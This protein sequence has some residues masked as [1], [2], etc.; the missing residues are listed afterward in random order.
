M[1]DIQA[2]IA[3]RLTADPFT[4]LIVAS[5]DSISVF[6][7]DNAGNLNVVQSFDALSPGGFVSPLAVANTLSVDFVDPGPLADLVAIAP[8]DDAVLIYPGNVGGTFDAPTVYS[9]GV[10]TPTTAV[11]ADVLGDRL[12]D[13]IVGHADGSIVFFEGSASG[14]GSTLVRRDDLTLNED[15]SIVDLVPGDFDSDENSDIVVATTTSAFVLFSSDDPQAVSPIT[16]GDFSAGLTGWTTEVIGHDFSQTP[17]RIGGLGGMAQFTENES[18]L[19]SLK[20]SIVIPPGTTELSFD[21]V[22]LGLDPIAGGV[23]D[24]FEVSLLDDNEQ[25]IVPSHDPDSTAFVNFSSGNSASLASGVSVSGR[26][27]TLDVSSLASGTNATLVFDLIGNPPGHSSVAAIDNVRLNPNAVFSD[28][29]TRTDLVGNYGGL[30]DVEVGD[31]DGDGNDDIV[32]SSP[33]TDSIVVFNGDGAGGFSEDSLSLASYSSNPGDIQLAPLTAGDEVDDIVVVM[34]DENLLLTP[35]GADVTAPA[36]TLLAPDNTSSLETFDGNVTLEFSEALRVS[37]VGSANNLSAY[38]LIGEGPDGVFGTSDDVR[39]AF[40]SANYDAVAMTVLLAVDASALPLADDNYRITV[41]GSDPALA[42]RDRVGNAVGGGNDIEFDF[43]IDTP[44]TAQSIAAIRATEGVATTVSTPFTDAGRV[45]NYTATIDW[46]D[47]VVEPLT[48]SLDA[49][50]FA[51]DVLGGHIYADNGRYDIVL[52]ITDHDDGTAIVHSSVIVA[53]SDPVLSGFNDISASE[54]TT[55]EFTLAAVTDSGFATGST[56]E[57]FSA[58]I[59][60]GDGSTPTTIADVIETTTGPAGPTT[61]DV[62]A[63]HAYAGEG[64]YTVTVTVADDDGGSATGTLQ[65]FVS[66]TAPVLAAI[67]PV[68]GNE[69]AT[70]SIAGTYRDDD[71][72]P[73]VDPA[74]THTLSIDWGDGTTELLTPVADANSQ[75]S[76]LADHVYADD[77]NYDIRVKVIDGDNGMDLQIAPATVGG[78]VPTTVAAANVQATAGTPMSFTLASFSD[79]GFTSS[80]AG[81]A[82]TFSVSVDWGDGSQITVDPSVVVTNGRPGINTTGLVSA[83][84]V[85]AAAGNYTATITVTDD[86]GLSSSDSLT[87]TVNGDDPTGACLPTLNFDQ[88]LSGVDLDAGT[89]IAEQWALWG[90]HISTDDPANHPAMIFDAENPTGGDTDLVSPAGTMLGNIL[91]ISEDNDSSDPD[92]NASGGTLIFDFDNPV[93]LDEVALLDID[94]NE[95]SAITLLDTSGNVIRA[96]TTIGSGD[97]TLQTVMLD[98]DN[99][100]RM[101]I[102]IDGSGAVTEVVFC[103]DLPTV[104]IVGNASAT[105]GTSYNVLTLSPD[106]AVTSWQLNFGDGT[107]QTLAGDAPTTIETFADGPGETTISG[108]AT[109][110]MNVYPASSLSVSI[111]NVIPTLS[112]SGGATVHAMTDYMIDLS[113]TDPGTD[114]IAGWVVDWGDGTLQQIAGNPNS[115]THTYEVEGEY[116]VVAHAFDEDYDGPSVGVTTPIEINAR[117]QEGVETFDLLIDDAVV[118]GF[119]TTTDLQTFAYDAA[120]AIAPNQIKIQFTNDL[121]DP[122]NGIDNNLIVDSITIAGQEYQTEADDVW[123]TGTWKSEDGI[124]DGYRGSEWLHSGGYFHFDH[125]ADDGSTIEITARGSEGFETLDLLIGGVIVASYSASTADQIFTYNAANVISADDV[126]IE[127]TNDFWDPANGIDAN[128]I[129][130]SINIDGRNYETEDSSVYSTGTWKPEDGI[131]PGY[132]ASEWMHAG[133]YFQYAGGFAGEVTANGIFNTGWVSNE[134]TLNVMPSNSLWL[135]DVNFDVDPAGVPLAAGTRITDQFASLGFTV[136]TNNANKPAMIFDS[137]QPTGGDQDLGTPNSHYG[138]PGRGNSGG[139]NDMALRNVL[140]ISE[141]NDAGDPDDNGNGGTLIFDFDNPVMIDEVGIM[142]IDSA[143][144]RIDLFDAVGALILSAPIESVG[145]NGVGRV[146]LDATGVSK[147][148][149]VLTG[150]GAVT[151]IEFCR[152]GAPIATAQTRFFVVD[153]KDDDIYRYATGGTSLGDFDASAAYNPRGITTTGEGNPVWVISEEGSPERVYVYD[154]DG[155][156]LLGDWTAKNLSNP[157]GIATDGTDIWVVDRSSDKVK[158]YAGGATRRAGHQYPADEFRLAYGNQDPRGITTDGQT[159]WVVDTGSDRVF[160]YDIAGNPI[161]WWDLDDKNTSPRGITINPNGGDGVWVVDSGDDAVYHYANAT[162]PHLGNRQSAVNVF[163]LAPGNNHPEGIA[164][165]VTMI[166]LGDSVSDNVSVAGEVDEWIFD[167]TVADTDIFVDFTTLAGGALTVSIT[168]PDGSSLFNRTSSFTGSLDSKRLTLPQVGTHTI[169]VTSTATATYD[170]TLNE[171][172]DD[173]IEPIVFGQVV[174]G[175]QDPIG[176]VDRYSFNADAGTKIFLDRLN[177]SGNS[178]LIQI[179]SPSGQKLLGSLAFLTDFNRSL[180][181]P[182]TGTYLFSVAYLSANPL[183]YSFRFADVTNVPTGSIQLN[184]LIEGTVD[185]PGRQLDYTF[186]ITAPIDVVLDAVQTASGQTWK[187]FDPNGIQVYSSLTMSD[188]LKFSLTDVGQYTLS[189]LPTNG[190]TG[191]ISFI[192]WDSTNP[193]P[194]RISPN[195]A[196]SQVVAPQ[197]DFVY[198]IDL[199]AGQDFLFDVQVNQSDRPSIAS[200]STFTLTAPDGSDL[201]VS[202]TLDQ[203]YTTAPLSG[204]YTLSTASFNPGFRDLDGNYTFRIQQRVVAGDPGTADSAGTEYYL[205]AN[206]GLFAIIEPKLVL[207]ST[208]TD[209]V[210]AVIDL[211]GLGW[212]HAT[213]VPPGEAVLVPLPRDILLPRGDRE[214]TELLGIYVLADAEIRAYVLLDAINSGDATTG[215]PT[216]ALGTEYLVETYGTTCPLG[217]SSSKLSVVATQDDTIVTITPT[218][219]AGQSPDR[220]EAGVPYDVFLDAGQTYQLQ[221]GGLVGNAELSGTEILSN[222]PVAVYGGNPETYVTTEGQADILAQQMPPVAAWGTRYV[223]VPLAGR[224]GGDTFRVMASVD[225]TDVTINGGIVATL[226]RGETYQSIIDGPAEFT[227]DAPVMVTRFGHGG[228]FDNPNAG[229]D[230][231]ETTGD[232]L[233]ITLVPTEQFEDGFVVLSDGEGINDHYLSIVTFTDGIDSVAVDPADFVAIGDGTFSGASLLVAAGT[234]SITSDTPTSVEVYGFGN[235]DSYGYYGG[236]RISPVGR[237]STLSLDP[238]TASLLPGN[239]HTVT[240]SVVDSVGQPLADVRVDFSVTGTTAETF[241]AYSGIDGLVSFTYTSDDIGT[242]TVTAAVG[243]ITATAD[244]NWL[245]APPTVFVTSPDQGATVVANTPLVIGGRALPGPSGGRIVAVSINGRRVDSIDP[246]GNYFASVTPAEG[247]QSYEIVAIDQYGQSATTSLTLDGQ[248][249]EVPFALS[250][251]VD[252]T[253][254]GELTFARTTFN[255]STNVLHTDAVLTATSDDGL[256]MATSVI[257]HPIDPSRVTLNAPDFTLPLAGGSDAVADGEGISFEGQI[258]DSGLA[259]GQSSAA[260]DIDF[261]N[262]DR[263]RFSFDYVILSSDNRA[264]VISSSPLINAAIGQPYEYSIIASDPDGDSLTYRMTSGPATANLDV[265]G[266]LSFAPVQADRGTH[267]IAIAVD[268]SRG[269]ITTESFTLVVGD[270]VP[271]R[272]PI[273]D[274]APLAGIASGDDYRFTTSAT[275]PDGDAVTYSLDQGP[276]GLNVDGTSG[277]LSWTGPGDGNYPITLRASDPGGAYS[278]QNFNLA[279]GDSGVVNAA[280]RLFGDFATTATVDSLYVEFPTAVDADGDTLTFDLLVAPVG[281]TITTVSAD[282]NDAR[283]R[284]DYTPTAADVGPQPVLLVVSDGNGGSSSRSFNVNVEA[285]ATP[286]PPVFDSTPGVFATVGQ[287]YDY[288]AIA[289]DPDGDDS[290]LTYS[291]LDGPANFQ[292]DPATGVVTFTP[293]TPGEVTVSIQATDA[294]GLTSG[295]T[296]TFDVRPVNVAPQFVSDPPPTVSAGAR[297]RYDALATDADDFVTYELISGPAGMKVSRNSGLTFWRPQPADIGNVGVTI[298]ATDDRGLSTEQTFTIGVTADVTPPLATVFIS[299]SPINIGE[300]SRISVDTGDDVAVASRTLTIDGVEVPIDSQDGYT[301]TAATAGIPHVVLTAVDT[302]GNTTTATLDPILRVLDP[303]DTTS[304]EIEITSPAPGDVVTYLTDIVGSVTDENLEYYEIQVALADTDDYSTISRVTFQPGAGG[305]GVVDDT[306][307]VFDPTMLA[308]DFYDVRVVAADT[309]GNVATLAAPLSVEGGAKLGNFR[310]ELT[311]LAI[312]LAGIPIQINRV[313]DTLDAPYNGD[314]GYGWKLDVASPRIRESVRISPA[315]AAGGGMFGANPFRLGTRVYINAPDGERVGFTFDPVPQPTL[316]G[317]RWT[318]RFTPDPGVYHQLEVDDVGLSQNPDGTFGLYLFGFNYNPDTYTL[319]TQD[320]MQYTYNQFDDIQL[321]SIKDR[322]NVTLTFDNTGIHS[323]VGPSITWTR[324]DQGRITEIL[325]TAGNPLAYTYTTSG[326]LESFTD[327]VGNVTTMTYLDDPKHHL[328]SITDPRD[329][330]VLSLAYDENGRLTGQ[331]DALGNSTAQSY[332]LE[333]NTEIIADRLG[334]ETTLVFDDRGNI[335]QEIDPLGFSTIYQYDGDDN[336]IAI[337]NRRGFTTNYEY[338]DRGNVTKITDALGGEMTMTFNAT[339]DLTSMTDQLGRLTQYG[340]DA[341]GNQ[342]EMIDA[343][344]N[345]MLQTFDDEGRVLTRTDMRGN[346]TNYRYDIGCGCPSLPGEVTYA[347]GTTVRIETE[348]RGI[349]TRITDQRGFS[350]NFDIDPAGRIASITDANGDTTT[351][352]YV[353]NLVTASTDALG[354]VTTYGHDERGNVTTITDPL[355]GVYRYEYDNAGDVIAEI[356]ELDRRTETVFDQRRD[357]IEV[358][359]AFGDSVRYRY[360]GNGNLSEF[361]DENEHRTTYT[362]DE[363]DRW[364]GTTDARGFNTS[365]NYDAVDNLIAFV[366]EIGEPTTYAYDVLD[367][368]T[369]MTAADGGVMTYAYDASGNR[370]RSTDPI[371][372]AT[373]RD[374]DNLDRLQSETDPDGFVT[375]YRY[376]AA[377]NLASLTDARGGVMRFEYDPLGRTTADIDQL[378]V[379]RAYNYDAVGNLVERIDRNGR[380]KTFVMDDLDRVITE[381]WT[382]PNDN[383]ANVITSTYDAVGNR[384]TLADQF[385]SHTF[386]YDVLHR[387]TF[388]SDSDALIG[389]THSL[390]YTYDPAG[391]RLSTTDADSVAVAYDYDDVD[392]LIGLTW[393]GSLIGSGAA[394]RY[395]RDGRGD[396]QQIDRFASAGATTPVGRTILTRDQIGRPT[397]MTHIDAADALLSDYDFTFDLAGQMLFETLDGITRTYDH[398]D[399]GQ[400]TGVTAADAALTQSFAYDGTGNRTVGGVTVDAANQILSD[401]AYEY[402]YDGEGN[403]TG[404]TRRDTGMAESYQYDHDNRLVGYTR[405]LATG[406]A[407]LIAEYRYDAAGRRISKTVTRPLDGTS[408]TI[409]YRYDGVEAWKDVDATGSTTARYL[410]GDRIDELTARHRVDA[411]LALYLRAHDGSVEAITDASGVVI[412]RTTYAAFG[413]IIAHTNP[414]VADRFGFTGREHDAETGLMHYRAR[415]Y[416]AAAGKFI[417]RD[418]LGLTAG[419]VN[420]TRY[421]G[422]APTEYVD[423][424]GKAAVGYGNKLRISAPLLGLRWQVQLGLGIPAGIAVGA[425]IGQNVNFGELL[426]IVFI[427]VADILDEFDDDDDGFNDPSGDGQGRPKTKGANRRDSQEID[428]VAKEKNVDRRELGDAVEKAKRG[429]GRGGSDNLTLDQIR[430]IADEII[431]FGNKVGD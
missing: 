35:L 406:E 3:Q 429:V 330:E 194:I 383:V 336:E 8:G 46:G 265:G 56:V 227:A 291:R 32:L 388:Q 17:G 277:G 319:V 54:N 268:D 359:N 211:P 390:T 164:D 29:L 425:Y 304:P 401:E 256:P 354:R 252:T 413:Q 70:V 416:D 254:S 208:S 371:G 47:G 239:P 165:P 95:S 44:I 192:I 428:R 410:P 393:S 386:A 154:T 40:D 395:Q 41:A 104:N 310:I 301:F 408:Q 195:T 245:G 100:A 160:A 140:I 293:T 120:G 112:I 231:S 64:N 345:S 271:N 93:Q 200:V 285:A 176:Q 103:R 326:D 37:G 403:R 219:L 235:F 243:N 364:A 53:N 155:E 15:S 338:D 109:D 272:G 409:G 21:L 322:N 137:S 384:L 361:V 217:C 287:S 159:I 358:I 309:N 87:I 18:F 423:P 188:S 156:T 392:D 105:E 253:L 356:D 264:P 63:S 220:R 77:G 267:S 278:L 111:N 115:V 55:T 228:R 269:G 142:D 335:T 368:L 6:H 199:I 238:A 402:T 75:A 222:K 38:S 281:M 207:A 26:T 431:E 216:D 365:S 98:A 334:N 405:S 302:S 12:P 262:P 339:N 117:G 169:T 179:E 57:T 196:I 113:A 297:Y 379:A 397:S 51:G 114:T 39:L 331:G 33:A 62:I 85:Y 22:S 349:S 229:N 324:D 168:A 263:D 351:L 205:A 110:G 20:Q 45:G 375:N 151:D 380:T 180:E 170:F 300:T 150:S 327:Q 23:P 11:V 153:R 213:D 247:T 370:T 125:D 376:D 347:D 31:V 36:V 261:A 1:T 214:A 284:I 184:E 107:S 162:F 79:P 65:A 340:Y 417:Q 348:A 130:D 286:L 362:Y 332:D 132:R 415:T 10:A 167:T 82:E 189:I 382:D 209:N 273:F 81:T 129:V 74:T 34:P 108:W 308:N 248:I 427:T 131:V 420:F 298:R 279:V 314:F 313:Y 426:G 387:L 157:Q 251:S 147:M 69:G 14:S 148:E 59:D 83:D 282:G 80:T 181:L 230:P 316:L 374:F 288:T 72:L 90:V 373:T 86:D 323:S 71:L 116:T 412:N 283:A 407:E 193:D 158:R 357:V 385:A 178:S 152:D 378:G 224:T 88:N 237:L 94:T 126:R 174:D 257:I 218:V 294:D 138:G 221:G 135:P 367:R 173:P 5:A 404:R 210:Q 321:Q 122:I 145:N 244:V 223:S 233:M 343:A 58:L 305:T 296:W 24:A 276:T 172:I 289:T 124:V 396:L 303:G 398:D 391:N 249:A 52:T 91:I 99:V 89:T 274:V 198:E 141:D 307:G 394:V 119:T 16:N 97:N 2:I 68:V 381:T 366:D 275:D 78:V 206:N 355:G 246:A 422:N 311:D 290:N 306:L 352:T 260:R 201:F 28:T 350:T 241:Y 215:L 50:G 48:V 234:H 187:L 266:V 121:H 101:E 421:V 337:T 128:L 312:P 299:D 144:N 19:T 372:R 161:N 166:D 190:N 255:R 73:G 400:L 106:V 295:Q 7:N 149:I 92:D 183:P 96:V 258:P 240:A 236:T 9:T 49:S 4:D 259:N 171:V 346:V 333:N 204:T 341:A 66:N 134:L 163:D 60:W 232:P 136:S 25:S 177:F 185:V 328:Q 76:Y 133:G 43:Q 225:G 67:D 419:D 418:P 186:D 325:D 389:D 292:I 191:D 353:D 342:I 30:V 139:S 123:S 411:G 182:E 118:A 203:D 42:I 212:F 430:E 197:Q 102:A 318:P 13:V 399:R 84:H 369:S 270:S 127:F 146:A 202:A 280:P 363:L 320:Q 226:D 360:D 317:T 377:G 175:I 250:S 329:I 344:G 315:E 27:V 424:L 61:A 143:G 414:A 242:D